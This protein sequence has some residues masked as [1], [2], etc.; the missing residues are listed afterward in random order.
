MLGFASAR[1]AAAPPPGRDALSEVRDVA[2][3]DVGSNSVRLVMYRL[4]GRAI[5]TIFNEKVLAG[6]GRGLST[7]RRLSPEGV[8]AAL[9]ALRRFRA[10]V[11]GAGVTEIYGA[12]TA[13]VREAADG[14]AF[15][16][17]IE[18]EAGFHID[19]L[20]GEAEARASA[21]GVAAGQPDAAGVVADLGGS[22]LE[23]VRLDRGQVGE[24][25]T[26]PLGPLALGAGSK[27][28]DLDRARQTI[29]DILGGVTGFS[30]AQLHAVGGGWRNLALLHMQIVGYPL[31]IVHQYSLGA[32]EALTAARLVARQSRGSLDR[33]S[34]IS[35]KRA[36]TL[37]YA[38][39]VLEALVERLGVRQITFSAYGLR[40]GLILQALPP[41]LRDRDPLL[42]GCRAIGAREGLVAALGP[43]LDAW[44][45]PAWGGLAPV[46]GGPRD[47]VLTTAATSLAD[48]GARLHPDHRADLVFAQVL[49][50][51]VAG[52][53]H[54]ERVFLATALFARFTS[55]SPADA[56][57]PMARLLSE[58]RTARARALGAALRLG[59]DLCGRSAAL[60]ARAPLSL[61]RRA[62]TLAVKRAHADLLLGEQ[63]GKRL[64]TLAESLQ[65]KPEIAIQD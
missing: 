47:A 31:N 51:P 50:A 14:P 1:R 57:G 55:A 38:A 19:V 12:A 54:A 61:D 24:G 2:V 49:R 4:E 34:G 15:I 6:L 41:E 18:Q 33:A 30:G 46:F 62:A 45:A 59:C 32:E 48:I 21:L 28:P 56:L 63:T 43:A 3:L 23:L 8:E 5:W 20:S 37:P 64:N 22:S 16:A 35:K 65:L 44:L 27:A 53:T 13:A 52:W 10:V 42:E 25:I 17:R 9:A 11:E 39:L 36:E 29:A 26:L 58:E 40:E 60:L 7:T